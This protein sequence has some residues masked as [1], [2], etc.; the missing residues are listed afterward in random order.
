[1]KTLEF[2]FN[3]VFIRLF[4][5]AERLVDWVDFQKILTPKANRVNLWHTSFFGVLKGAEP[6]S[7]VC[8]TQK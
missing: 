4:D 3:F 1:M 5:T 2:K 8:P 6:K 7:A